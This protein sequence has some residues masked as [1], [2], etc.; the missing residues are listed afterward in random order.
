M[1]AIQSFINLVP[2]TVAQSLIYG[3]I[4]LGIM[5]PFRLLSFPDLTSE[6]AFPLGGCLCGALILAGINP[7]APGDP[8]QR[9]IMTSR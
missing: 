3:F 1:T 6:G 4:A 8:Y 2:V 5:I 9:H 7:F